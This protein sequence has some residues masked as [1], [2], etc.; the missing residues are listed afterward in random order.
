MSKVGKVVWVKSVWVEE[1]SSNKPFGIIRVPNEKYYFASQVHCSKDYQLMEGDYVKFTKDDS[2]TNIYARRIFFATKIEKSVDK[3]NPN[4]EKKE[5]D[6]VDILQMDYSPGRTSFFDEGYNPPEPSF[7]SKGFNSKAAMKLE[8]MH[9]GD[10]FIDLLYQKKKVPS[11]GKGMKM[12]LYSRVSGD[13]NGDLVLGLKVAKVTKSLLPEADVTMV[14]P[15]DG[16]TSASSHETIT[17]RLIKKEEMKLGENTVY[18]GIK[19]M[20]I[21]TLEKDKEN[22]HDRTL[23]MCVPLKKPVTKFKIEDSYLQVGECAYLTKNIRGGREIKTMLPPTYSTIGF[24]SNDLGIAYKEIPAKKLWELSEEIPFR[25]FI[26]ADDYFG[27]RLYFSYCHMWEYLFAY[28]HLVLAVEKR[29]QKCGNTVRA[30]DIVIPASKLSKWNIIP[31]KEKILR[32]QVLQD[33]AEE[34]NATLCVYDA[35]EDSTGEK[36]EKD[37]FEKKHTGLVINII[38]AP[39]FAHDDFLT[40]STASQPLAVCTGDQSL[41]ECMS[42]GKTF[43]YEIHQHKKQLHDD[44]L[45]LMQ[46]IDTPG[47]AF[48]FM[49]ECGNYNPF[50]HHG[51]DNEGVVVDQRFKYA[52]W[53]VQSDEELKHLGIESRI[54]KKMKEPQSFF[55]GLAEKL[56][57]ADGNW[58][59]TILDAFK[60]LPKVLQSQYKMKERLSGKIN[61]FFFVK[62]LTTPQGVALKEAV[63]CIEMIIKNIIE[64]PEDCTDQ[65]KRDNL[66]DELR[67]LYH[68][69]YQVDVKVIIG[70]IKLIGCQSTFQIVKPLN[71]MTDVDNSGDQSKQQQNGNEVGKLVLPPPSEEKITPHQVDILFQKV[72]Q[73]VSDG[74]QVLPKVSEDDLLL[75]LNEV[76][77]DENQQNTQK[78]SKAGPQSIDISE[79]GGRRA[80]PSSST[81]RLMSSMSRAKE[82]LLYVM[83]EQEKL[84]QEKE[85][86]KRQI[87]HLRQKQQRQKDQAGSSMSRR[88]AHN[89]YR[90]TNISHHDKVVRHPGR[91]RAASNTARGRRLINEINREINQERNSRNDFVID[92]EQWI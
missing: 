61:R 1:S 44:V 87:A 32:D 51:I 77:E 25:S 58:N 65:N 71:M 92:Q 17:C 6:K 35:K 81:T 80:R 24:G 64:Q 45:A 69:I 18:E 38:N 3:E 73:R 2:S 62:N 16:G 70:G 30:I 67:H 66:Q 29:F 26:N 46:I 52:G 57:A 37:D 34:M 91:R 22:N 55:N 86:I 5:E 8:G 82:N 42:I 19:V 79:R 88:S 78:E 20:N 14:V 31:W 83:Q 10:R 41:I 63:Q 50:E 54:K 21:P 28:I 7:N 53:S 49:K 85:K 68:L 60:K 4:E 9:K 11:E 76:L 12:L 39:F 89:R 84:A 90:S 75:V 47:K 72:S 43:I 33:S 36:K 56:V 15:E 27:R 59:S 74:D 40:M 48:S 13:G 23:L